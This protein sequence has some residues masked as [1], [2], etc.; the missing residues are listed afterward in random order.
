MEIGRRIKE[1][2]DKKKMSLQ[3][4][5][6]MLN[7]PISKLS[8]IERGEQGINVDDLQ[9]IVRVL[10]IDISDIIYTERNNSMKNMNENGKYYVSKSFVFIA[11]KYLV[12]DP[13]NFTDNP[14]GKTLTKELP[15]L[16]VEKAHINCS[17]YLVTGSVGKGQFAEIPWL[18]VFR[19]SI[20]ETATKG[21]YIVY[22]FTADMKGLYL[23][24]NQ[25]FTFFKDK[26]GVKRG[27]EEIRKVAQYLQG[28]C[29]T[30]P[31]EFKT[32]SIDLKATGVL[33]KGYMLGHIAGKYY[34]INKLPSD[35]ELMDELR[36][37][38]SVYE[39]VSA[40]IG[41]RSVEEFYNYVIAFN[42]GL[43]ID[44]ETVNQN[45]DKIIKESE[46]IAEENVYDGVPKNR[47]D[48]VKDNSG[49]E[50][51]PRNPYVSVRALKLAGYEC[52][53]NNTHSTFTKKSSLKKYTEPHHL[54]PI[55]AYKDFD[56]SLD[57]EENICS[58][59]S[60]CHNCLHYGIDSER[61]PIL[62][63][64]Y[65]K[66]KELLEKA[67]IFVEFERLKSYYGIV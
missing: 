34:D 18:A 1:V 30:I 33:G 65:D 45:I 53:N 5:S 35:S 67:G 59:C 7:W 16:I 60:N 13:K 12:Q 6:D 40:I 63:K 26:F 29:N 49:S 55:S 20:T 43:L 2:R 42:E 3:E 44:E 54:I 39:E 37:M 62:R 27:R 41:N 14:I 38:M 32:N 21:I 64:L 28:I 10:N 8:K 24:L 36:N 25:G 22:L 52:E 61:E 51:Y 15:K 66:R 48:P 46:D 19:R 31:K 50:K 17:N 23:S 47:K 57:I 11:K 58:L 56:Y 9:Q 4:I